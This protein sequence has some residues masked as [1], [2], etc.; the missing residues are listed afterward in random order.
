MLLFQMFIGMSLEK[1]IHT[2]NENNISYIIEYENTTNEEN[3]TSTDEVNQSQ[4]KDLKN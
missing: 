2:L 3:N 1:E 4:E